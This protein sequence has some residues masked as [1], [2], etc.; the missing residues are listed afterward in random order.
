[1]PAPAVSVVD[2][3]NVF[4]LG[5]ANRVSQQLATTFAP[6][7][8]YSLTIQAARLKSHSFFA[9]GRLILGYG[10]ASSFT[11]L[12]SVINTDNSYAL[13]TLP[14]AALGEWTTIALNYST[15]ASG[16][17]LGQNIVV[18][19]AG[20]GVSGAPVSYVDNFFLIPEPT[21]AALLG[22]TA[23][24]FLRRRKA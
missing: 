14:D 12:A 4:A 24:I 7:V 22:L 20:N 5:S 11:T 10:T 23:W 1:M 3:N 13:D 18:A 21:S 16:P 8:D 2:D 15:G 6:N 9:G 19:F 17:E